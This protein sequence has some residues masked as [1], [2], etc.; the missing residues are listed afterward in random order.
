[1]SV[2]P[3]L[4]VG[5]VMERICGK[6]Y[7]EILHE[8]IFSDA[9]ITH[10]SLHAPAKET[11]D[12]YT[13]LPQTRDMVGSPAGGSWITSEDLARFGQWVYKTWRIQTRSATR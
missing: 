3:I 1:M 10:F 12:V 6:E 13:D 5:L 7:L 2:D 4:L 9:E 11:S 8:H